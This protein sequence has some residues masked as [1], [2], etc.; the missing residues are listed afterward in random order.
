MALI[1]HVDTSRVPY[2]AVKAVPTPPRTKTWG[3]IGHGEFIDLLRDATT[4]RYDIVK[5][6]YSMSKNGGKM[7]GTFLLDSGSEDGRRMVGFR[8]SI[9]KSLAAGLT[10]GRR[11][12]VCDNLV[13]DGE[14]VDYQK[15][16][17]RLTLQILKA[18][19]AIAVESLEKR[20]SDFEAWYDSLHGFRLTPRDA[21]LLT[22][23]AMEQGVLPGGSF[24]KFH[25]LF[26]EKENQ[27]NRAEYDDTLHG[28]HGAVT[29]L[30]KDN[31]LVTTGPRHTGLVRLIRNAA[32]LLT[33]DGEL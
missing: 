9:D 7:F 21:R 27:E 17:G 31:S 33:Q 2:E 22:F 13:F 15:H 5:E 24:P 14:F 11:V 6:E 26:F 10:A 29:Q 32:D 3:A 30:W 12:T 18:A 25:D 19:A 23:R 4:G 1:A 28:F 16:V 8:N 20:F